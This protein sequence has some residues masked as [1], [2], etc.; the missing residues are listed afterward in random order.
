MSSKRLL[1]L[2]IGRRVLRR[3]AFSESFC[4]MSPLPWKPV[5]EE[6]FS[7][8]CTAAPAASRFRANDLPM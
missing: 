6:L 8:G 2:Q 7:T 1:G 3:T 4:T 5:S